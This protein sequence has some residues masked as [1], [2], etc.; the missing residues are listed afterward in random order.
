[1]L[2]PINRMKHKKATDA[3][4]M[5]AQASLILYIS[6]YLPSR[7]G[8]SPDYVSILDVV[9]FN[10]PHIPPI[11][12][13]KSN[14]KS[15]IVPENLFQLR[16]NGLENFSVNVAVGQFFGFIVII[17][18]VIFCRPELIGLGYFSFNVVAHFLKCLDKLGSYLFLLGVEIENLG[19]ILRTDIGALA[20]KLCKIVGLEKQ[21]CQLLVADYFGIIRDLD[22]LGVA[23]FVGADLLVGGIVNV[24]ARVSDGC[25]DNAGYFVEV[26]FGPPETAGCE[27][28]FSGPDLLLLVFSRYEIHRKRIHT[29]PR[30]LRCHLFAEKDVAEVAAAVVAENLSAAAIGIALLFDGAFNL[31]VE[32]GPAAVGL[33]LRRRFVKRCSALGAGIGS[34][35]VVVVIF[36]AE[37]AFSTLLNDNSLL[38]EGKFFVHFPLLIKSNLVEE[39]LYCSL[40]EIGGCDNPE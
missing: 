33:E 23:G 29:I 3:Q 19:S 17:L 34:F 13:P 30:V 11:K 16:I 24:A 4:L 1:M 31:V 8:K 28:C 5:Q 9:V 22:G 15:P 25:G 14:T 20:V 38:F 27:Y 6:N 21:L 40:P 7:Q 37:R 2:R 12:S 35:F 39:N 36:A 10:A 32:A 18:V 26:I